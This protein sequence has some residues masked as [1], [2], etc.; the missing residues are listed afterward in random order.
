[1]RYKL[2]LSSVVGLLALSGNVRWNKV[3]AQSEPKRV[4]IKAQRFHYDPSELTLKKGEPVILVLKS[5]D[6]P[7]GLRFRDLDVALRV[8]KGGTS[9]VEFTPDQV[10]DFTG[11]C[12]VFCGAEHGSMML[13]LHVVN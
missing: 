9:E 2:L 12:W 3:A 4:E 5:E 11:Q 10:G 13:T 1:M 8:D 6:V 7:H